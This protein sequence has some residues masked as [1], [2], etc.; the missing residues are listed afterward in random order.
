MLILTFEERERIPRNEGELILNFIDEI[1][2]KREPG[3][4]AGKFDP[5]IKKQLLANIAWRMFE[6]GNKN[7]V[8]KRFAFSGFLQRLEELKESGEAPQSYA[9]LEIWQEIQNNH[10]LIERDGAVY[11]PH[12][13]YQE[14]FVGIS[15]RDSSFD[16]HWNPRF[17]EIAIRFAPLEV[18]WYGNPRFESGITMLEVVPA[19]FRLQALVFV[20]CINPILSKEAYFKLEP[21]YNPGL[22][23]E[24]ISL[25]KKHILSEEHQG[26]YHRNLV[27]ALGYLRN[28]GICPLLMVASV[29]CPNWE[30]R[31]QAVT[32]IWMKCHNDYS[33]PGVV[34]HLKTIACED[35]N[36]RVRKAAISKLIGFAE[37]TNSD[38]IVLYLVDRVMHEPQGF[39]SDPQILL[40]KILITSISL[41]K[42][43]SIAL[44]TEES[45]ENRRRA[46]WAIGYS[47]TKNEELRNVLI[48]LAKNDTQI[49]V[50]KTAV[51][52]LRHFSSNK[53]VSALHFVLQN[54]QEASI[55]ERAVFSLDAC[56]D[57]Y[58]GKIWLTAISDPDDSVGTAVIEIL[59]N[60][61]NKRYA[62]D[63]FFRL[64]RSSNTLE[65]TRALS[66]L[67]RI[68]TDGVDR[69][70][71]EAAREL[72]FHT[73]ES[74]K[75][76]RLKIAFGLR[77]YDIN[78]SN[79]I[80]KELLADEDQKVIDSA[81]QMC[82]ELGIL[83]NYS[84]LDKK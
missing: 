66:L 3:K 81:Q 76:T 55:R 18:K 31:E 36:R 78:L 23:E 24:F 64:S 14:L 50:R 80:I 42:L 20:A 46:V 13:L 77:E 17:G 58:S 10:L 4:T 2:V 73:S 16:E 22:Q 21:E 60:I 30:G 40:P 65:R 82:K 8:S 5:E 61:H 12:P 49:K 38:D 74:D 27:L 79:R 41:K 59:F 69:K 25:L 19:K 6:Q 45:V 57:N 83:L 29:G 56:K 71:K 67:S 54:E 34:K 52:E 43:K 28:S 7:V 68:A 62:L 47:G 33:Y 26:D 75:P 48:H 70:A 39:V 44:D 84:S 37:K 53:T 15:L 11:W 1:L 51:D 9:G 63:H 32:E 35:N 72:S